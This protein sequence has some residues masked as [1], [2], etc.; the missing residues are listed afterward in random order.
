MLGREV[1]CSPVATEVRLAQRVDHARV[2]V[3]RVDAEGLQP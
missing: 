3:L 1:P 2:L